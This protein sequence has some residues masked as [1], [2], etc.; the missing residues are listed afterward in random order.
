MHAGFFFVYRFESNLS[1]FLPFLQYVS[2]RNIF[3]LL[4]NALKNFALKVLIISD[5]FVSDA[6]NEI[7]KTQKFKPIFFDTGIVF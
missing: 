6:L 3:M 1:F 5:F 2:I 4:Y 7:S